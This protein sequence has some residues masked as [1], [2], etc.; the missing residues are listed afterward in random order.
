MSSP[1]ST[2]KAIRYLETFQ[3]FPCE[4]SLERMNQ[5]L[6]LVGDPQKK[7]RAIH[8][9]GTN[10][11][12]S[13]CATAASILKA[14]GYKVGLFTSPH[15][16]KYNERIQINGRA[17]SDAA[18]SRSLQK[19]ASLLEQEPD[20]T[21]AL[22]EV[23]TVIMFLYFWERKVDIAVLEVGIG[24]R[25]DSTNLIEHSVSVITNVDLE[26][27]AILGDTKG[28]IAFQ[29][30]GII[31]PNSV[32][33]VGDPDPAVQAI[34]VEEA[35]KLEA[36][37][38]L[39][40]P[41]ELHPLRHN[42]HGQTFDFGPYKKL[43]IPLLGLHQLGNAALAILAVQALGKDFPVSEKQIRAGL[44]KVR[45]PLR[46]E[47]LRGSPAF[48][49]DVGH[50][51]HGIKAVVEAVEDYFPRQKRVL[52]LGASSDKP[53]REMTERLAV[54][55]D[56]VILTQAHHGVDPEELAGL[57]PKGKKS[58]VTHSVKEALALA[59]KLSDLDGLV[60]VLGGLYLAAEAKAL[61]R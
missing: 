59:K 54:L 35:E 4:P 19:M 23:L 9:T 30:A 49:L 21:P 5:L 32:V 38:V 20:L 1:W 42:L 8:V 2:T 16:Q 13:T 53:Y 18:L 50:N 60:L 44:K 58:F 33:I 52:V 46:F 61:L 11:K 31:K 15:L 26:H 27:T 14:A 6:R 48:L 56:V 55:S 24:G 39:L 34:F 40:K 10:G 41:A 43:F 36:R 51:P 12:G 22:F 25:F 29:K 17:I 45:W 47:L 28:K 57:L 37:M 3:R 7:L